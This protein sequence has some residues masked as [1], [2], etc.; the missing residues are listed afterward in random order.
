MR[1]LLLLI[2]STGL[3]ACTDVDTQTTTAIVPKSPVIKFVQE[4]KKQ[5]PDWTNNSVNEKKISLIF[6]SAVNTF[7]NKNNILDSLKF[8]LE[9]VNE[10]KKGKYAVKLVNDDLTDSVNIE[11]IGLIPESMVS[12][13]TE[14]QNYYAYG[15]YLKNLSDLEPYYDYGLWNVS[16]GILEDKVY[17]GVNLY[18]IT[19]LK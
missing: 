17:F 8:K 9:S 13:L 5:H 11:I 2:L 16:P 7:L 3:L 18:K 10:Y 19:D 15:K 4:F 12:K 1:K 14:G 6:A